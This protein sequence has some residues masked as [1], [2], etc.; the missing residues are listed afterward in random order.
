M[1]QLILPS[2]EVTQASLM[3]WLDEHFLPFLFSRQ[4][5]FRKR[6][7][8]LEGGD[9]RATRTSTS[10]SS[11]RRALRKLACSLFSSHAQMRILHFLSRR[12]LPSSCSLCSYVAG[13]FMTQ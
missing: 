13:L 10:L 2:G 9:L 4:M 1:V 3:L 5:P 7:Q 8:S 6:E 11:M 12:V